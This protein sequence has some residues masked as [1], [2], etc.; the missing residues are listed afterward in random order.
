MASQLN[1]TERDRFYPEL[2][3]RDGEFCQYCQRTRTEV[4]IL[5]I[6][7]TKYERPLK[8]ENMKLFC[9]GCNHLNL[10]SKQTIQAAENATPEHK[11]NMIKEPY[12]RQ[13]ILGKMYENNYHYPLD[14]IIDSGAYIV[15]VS[16]E[17]IKRYLRPLC[18]DDGPFTKP[19]GWA[20]GNLHIFV[21]G[22]EPNY[23]SIVKQ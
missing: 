3:R 22:K 6:H 18:S 20:D 21:K 1:K 10:F 15:G 19:I 13:W 7:E 4:G 8:L 5:E 23:D 16:T 2:V 14:E 17:T 12:F 9:H 11:K